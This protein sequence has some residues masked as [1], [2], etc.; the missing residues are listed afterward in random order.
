VCQ[1]EAWRAVRGW[2]ST[3]AGKAAF[4]KD[5]A[6]WSAFDGR[7]KALAEAQRRMAKLPGSAAMLRGLTRFE[8]S[9]RWSIQRALGSELFA[10]HCATGAAEAPEGTPLVRCVEYLN[11]DPDGAPAAAGAAA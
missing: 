2:L 7:N 4:A 6:Q 8:P 1:S 11:D 10:A 9:R 3:K 5:R